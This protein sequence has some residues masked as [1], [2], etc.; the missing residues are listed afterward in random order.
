MDS[1]VLNKFLT[2]MTDMLREAKDFSMQQIPIV[3]KEIL[4]YNLMMNLIGVGLGALFVLVGIVLFIKI[5]KTLQASNEALNDWFG[6]Y[7]I[8]FALGLI[9]SLIIHAYLPTALQIY[10]APRVYLLEYMSHL[11][12]VM[13]H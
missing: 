1:Q 7:V 6:L 12:K 11:L 9:G 5:N 4:S 10:L 3:A 2:E 13:A 8:P